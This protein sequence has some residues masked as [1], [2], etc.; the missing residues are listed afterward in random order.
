MIHT[1]K[2]ETVR[3]SH[4]TQRKSVTREAANRAMTIVLAGFLTQAELPLLVFPLEFSAFTEGEG[5]ELDTEDGED[6]ETGEEWM[7]ED[8]LGEEEGPSCMIKTLGP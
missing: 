4:E 1:E 2:L 3:F 6:G 8:G 7:E 5:E